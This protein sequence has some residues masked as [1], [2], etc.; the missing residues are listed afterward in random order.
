MSLHGLGFLQIKLG[1]DQRL[2]VWHPD[3]PRRACFEHS[4]I[5]D[6]RF[7]F[8]STV[9]KGMQINDVY[10]VYQPGVNGFPPDMHASHRAYLHEGER[11]PSGNRPW[12][13]RELL[14]VGHVSRELVSAGETYHMLPKVFHATTPGGDGR[15]ATLMTKVEVGDTGARSLCSR[16]VEPDVDFDRKQMSDYNMWQ[17]VRDVLGTDF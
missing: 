15:V 6:H 2:H 10:S 5:H 14:W 8:K 17:V 13:P 4:S 1:A 9:L 3:L 7:G 12:I 11:L 16:Y